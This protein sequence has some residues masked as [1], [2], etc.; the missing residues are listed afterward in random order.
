MKI[1]QLENSLLAITAVLVVAAAGLAWLAVAQHPTA[2]NLKRAP[3]LS[4]N[5]V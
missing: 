4:V 1:E 3:L 2:R 5:G